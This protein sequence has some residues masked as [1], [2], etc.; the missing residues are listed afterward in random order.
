M[1]LSG[2][3]NRLLSLNI[4]Q[5]HC[6]FVPEFYLGLTELHSCAHRAILSWD[7]VTSFLS[8]I[9]FEFESI[10][11]RRN[12]EIGIIFTFI[13]SIVIFYY[14]WFWSVVATLTCKSVLALHVWAGPAEQVPPMRICENSLVCIV[15]DFR[16]LHLERW[17]GTGSGV[18]SWKPL[19]MGDD[20]WIVYIYIFFRQHVTSIEMWAQ[21]RRV[22]RPTT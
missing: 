15:D 20:A 3:D 19:G 10:M 18:L 11:K 2:S 14:F 5:N 1:A 16:N 4:I 22:V 13:L 6:L 9:L 7:I 21:G 12:I 8:G 17:L